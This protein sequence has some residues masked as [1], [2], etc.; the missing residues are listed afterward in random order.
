MTHCQQ[1]VIPVLQCHDGTPV[2]CNKEVLE[3]QSLI[4]HD[5]LIMPYN[6]ER[7]GHN[8]PKETTYI[9]QGIG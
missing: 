2:I 3:V 1:N 9:E 5:A 7:I 4:T 8:G 6:G